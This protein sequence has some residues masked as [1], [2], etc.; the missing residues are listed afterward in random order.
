MNSFAEI[1]DNVWCIPAEVTSWSQGGYFFISSDPSSQS[2][3]L[4][5]A[6]WEATG[7]PTGDVYENV[8]LG[9]TFSTTIDGFTAGSTLPNS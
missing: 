3:W 1:K 8:T 5:P 4:T 9:S 2:G 6:E 7:I